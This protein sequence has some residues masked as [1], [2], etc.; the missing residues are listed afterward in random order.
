MRT[1][2]NGLTA[3]SY[4]PLADIDPRATTVILDALREAGVAAY[5]VAA[6][7][8]SSLGWELDVPNRPVDRLYVDAAASA[9]AR[10]VL[11]VAFAEP[12]A[13]T[14]VP[15]T[16]S[17]ADETAPGQAQPKPDGHNGTMPAD[18]ADSGSAAT[19]ASEQVEAE[20]EHAGQADLDNAWKQIIA[21]FEASP[22]DEV[23]RW[24]ADEDIADDGPVREGR[25]VRKV[26][27]VDSVE[28]TGPRDGEPGTAGDDGD[29]D[30]FVPPLPPPLPPLE[31]VTKLAWAGV[32]GGPALL[33]AYAF[34]LGLPTWIPGAAVFAFIGGFTT[35][36]MRLKD[37]SDE[38]PDDGAVV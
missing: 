34:G 7:G 20:R 6:T 37:H 5:A 28:A 23:P 13:G 11:D 32:L 8:R 4:V 3:A 35:L 17:E 33:L 14:A 21:G 30:H 22:A 15:R 16:T 31:P 36:V 27:A 18:A 24:P 12:D 1:R 19:P 10:G 38:D 25:V 9:A 29:E 2:G 26:E